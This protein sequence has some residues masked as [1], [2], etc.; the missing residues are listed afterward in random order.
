MTCYR[1]REKVTAWQMEHFIENLVASVNPNVYNDIRAIG[2]YF[3]ENS[4]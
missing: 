3:G 1:K 2:T 4:R